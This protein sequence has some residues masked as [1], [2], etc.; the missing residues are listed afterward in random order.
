M[1][2]SDVRSARSDQARTAPFDVA[3]NLVVAVDRSRGRQ[4]SP[5]GRYQSSVIYDWVV[6][7]GSLGSHRSGE[8][9]A[10]FQPFLDSGL[11]HHFVGAVLATG[12]PDCANR[13]SVDL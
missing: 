7:C 9:G 10:Q 6:S 13:L 4:P 8:F 11:C 1:S 5:P 2:T 12:D 3:T